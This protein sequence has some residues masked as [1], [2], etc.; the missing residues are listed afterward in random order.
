MP[1]RESPPR[2]CSK[3]S[4]QTPAS[5]TLTYVYADQEAVLGPLAL[6]KEPHAYDLCEVHSE[7]LTAPMGW[8]I[9]RFRP[10]PEAS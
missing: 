8:R 4:C 1:H 9:L 10:Y 5:A 2:L 7:R 3:N 6:S